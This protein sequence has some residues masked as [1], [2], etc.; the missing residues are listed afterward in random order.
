M[1]LRGKWVARGNSHYY[2]QEYDG[3]KCEATCENHDCMKLTMA[4]FVCSPNLHIARCCRFLAQGSSK[5][6][7]AEEICSGYT[8]VAL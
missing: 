6:K 1:K 3:L 4:I 7:K 5:G 2:E 8:N